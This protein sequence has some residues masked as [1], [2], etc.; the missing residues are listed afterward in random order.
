MS[1]FVCHLMAYMYIKHIVLSRFVFLFLDVVRLL[2]AV[3]ARSHH[4]L[5]VSLCRCRDPQPIH[6]PYYL[7]R[8]QCSICHSE[9]F[10]R[11]KLHACLRCGGQPSTPRLVV[12]RQCP[13]RSP[14]ARVCQ[15]HASVPRQ[16]PSPAAPTSSRT[17]TCSKLRVQTPH[18]RRTALPSGAPSGLVYLAPPPP[19]HTAPQ[20]D[21]GD[22]MITAADARE[23]ISAN[24]GR[25]GGSC[26]D[27]TR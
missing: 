21:S 14:V 7:E 16:A 19:R 12:S 8:S 9:R 18:E 6:N 1:R 4:L 20:Q 17:S 15:C 10:A 5:G 11:H 3:E 24:S 2:C 25:R 22:M 13:R 23:N 26:G 27:H